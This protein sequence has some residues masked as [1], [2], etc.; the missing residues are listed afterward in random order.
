MKIVRNMIGKTTGTPVKGLSVKAKNIV[1]GSTYQLIEAPSNSGKYVSPDVPH[2]TYEIIVGDDDTL[3]EVTVAEGRYAFFYMNA[4]IDSAFMDRIHL[5]SFIADDED[6]A[7]TDS[8]SKAIDMASELKASLAFDV[9]SELN[10]VKSTESDLYIDLCGKT[11]SING[12]LSCGSFTAR[13]GNISLGDE[14]DIISDSMVSQR[15]MSFICVN[16]SGNVSRFIDLHKATYVQCSGIYSC[17][18]TGK[19]IFSGEYPFGTVDRLK[20]ADYKSDTGSQRRKDLDAFMQVFSGGVYTGEPALISDAL[21]WLLSGD[22]KS[23]IDNYLLSSVQKSSETIAWFNASNSL[24]GVGYSQFMEAIEPYAYG[25]RSIYG[26][27]RGSIYGYYQRSST[28]LGSLGAAEAE[29]TIYNQDILATSGVIWTPSSTVSI[30]SELKPSGASVS[31]SIT[32][33]SAHKGIWPK[34]SVYRARSINP[35]N[36]VYEALYISSFLPTVYGFVDAIPAQGR[37]NRLNYRSIPVSIF[38]MSGS[39]KVELAHNEPVILDFCF[40][41]N[42]DA[43]LQAKEWWS[44]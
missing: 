44:V 14:C 18:T 6:F 20:L 24:R 33:M 41:N 31:S 19:A 39:S 43:S 36:G 16:L 21:A 34:T 15:C 3:D 27:L 25:G 8:V 10:G 30:P 1:S 32:G 26:Y 38:R 5:S 13:G 35:S 7:Y 11:F 40:S 12:Q 17:G 23:K 2:G 4:L 37:T 9:D 29:N 22:R 42:L 28:M